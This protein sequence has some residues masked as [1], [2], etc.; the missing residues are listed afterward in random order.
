MVNF[1]HFSHSDECIAL[2]L[3]CISLLT[4]DI[5]YYFMFLLAICTASFVKYLVKSSI[6]L[7]GFYSL[8][9][10]Y[11]V[12]YVLWIQVFCLIPNLPIVFASLFSY[13]C[14]LIRKS[15]QFWRDPTYF[16]FMLC[17]FNILRNISLPKSCKNFLL[18]FL[19]EVFS[20]CVIYLC[21]WSF[22]S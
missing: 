21:L 2:V 5:D 12:L 4:N 3:I 11:K 17:A 7:L 18:C 8:Y 6:F 20:F 15:F 1:V 19:L 10:A 22:L 9:L 14:L 16:S 13:W